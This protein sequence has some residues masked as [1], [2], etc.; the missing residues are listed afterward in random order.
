MVSFIG[1]VKPEDPE[2]ITD[3]LYHLQLYQ[4][5]LAMSGIQAHNF[6]GDSFCICKS[7]YHTVTSWHY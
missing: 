2:K 6:S 7:N 3:K 5:Q 4:V 1:G